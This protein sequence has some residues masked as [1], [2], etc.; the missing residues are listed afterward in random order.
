MNGIFRLQRYNDDIKFTKNNIKIN[1]NKNIVEKYNNL[2]NKNKQIEIEQNIRSMNWDVFII[3][4]HAYWWTLFNIDMNDTYNIFSN[5]LESD[6]YIR[7]ITNNKTKNIWKGKYLGTTTELKKEN[8]KF[9]IILLNILSPSL[10]SLEQKYD[11]CKIEKIVYINRL[12]TI[13][14]LFDFLEKNGIFVLHLFGLYCSQNEEQNLLNILSFMFDYLIIYRNMVLCF[15][16]NPILKK[17]DIIN[18]INSV[19]LQKNIY[20]ESNYNT[21]ELINYHENNLLYKSKLL[22]LKTNGYDDEYNIYILGDLISNYYYYYPKK[23]TDIFRYIVQYFKNIYDK[24]LLISDAIY[25]N[26]VYK[27]IV[28]LI[29][30]FNVK[31]CLEIG[32]G[33]GLYSFYILTNPKVKLISI[34][35][36]QKTKWLNYGSKLLKEFCFN[37]RHTLIKKDYLNA[38]KKMISKYTA[39]IDFIFVDTFYINN[40]YFEKKYDKMNQPIDLSYSNIDITYL[41]YYHL[42]LKVNGIIIINYTSNAINNFFKDNNYK[43]IYVTDIFSIYHKINY[44]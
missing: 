32:M 21:T 9:K 42:L 26:K 28:N 41:I 15:N 33:F 23:E 29:N 6:F 25:N 3:N 17:S 24:K 11:D 44:N 5:N 8:K 36:L 43:K 18:I 14:Y 13:A 37:E 22:Y 38:L 30:N 10:E 2:I 39:S 35:P 16:F 19:K 31:N 20:V 27:Y 12:K 1:I 40:K 7:K 34:D 4:N